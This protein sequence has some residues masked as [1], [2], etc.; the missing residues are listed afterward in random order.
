MAGSCMFMQKGPLPHMLHAISCFCCWVQG[1]MA[2]SC[3][4]M[5]AG[6]PHAACPASSSVLQ[7]NFLSLALLYHIHHTMSCFMLSVGENGRELYVHAN[8]AAPRCLPC[9]YTD[10]AEAGFQNPNPQY[11]ASRVGAPAYCMPCCSNNVFAVLAIINCHRT[12]A[13][14]NLRAFAASA[15]VIVRIAT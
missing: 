11:I 3:M 10:P 14:C 8:R 4:C 9:N 12:V 5:Q 7:P 2:G 13:A 6:L 15:A 1:R